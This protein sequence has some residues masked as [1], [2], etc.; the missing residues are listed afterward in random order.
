MAESVKL[1][2]LK[3]SESEFYQVLKERVNSYFET[4]K[5]SKHANGHMVFKTF[6][7]LSM[8]GLTYA[9]VL[10]NPFHPL[11]QLVIAMALGF[12]TAL[13]GLNI[14][15]DALH[16]AYSSNQKI[17]SWLGITFNLIGA[18]DYIW[19]IKH[20]IIHH[21]FTNIPDH[22]DDIN[23]AKIL[24]MEPTQK[25]KPIHRYQHFYIFL[26]YPLSSLSW[27]FVKDFEKFFKAKISS[28]VIKNHPK[29]ELYRLIFFKLVYYTIYIVIPFTVIDLPWYYILIGFIAMHLVEGATLSFIFQL[30]HVFEGNSYPQPDKEG[31]LSRPWADHQ[32]FTTANFGK[33]SPVLNFLFGGLNMQ[34]EHH[35]FPRICHV[36]YKNIS[37]IVQSTARE[38]NLP[39]LESKTFGGAIRSHMDMMKRL[40]RED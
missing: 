29:I 26:L 25:R 37:P 28:K 2:F 39:Y 10:I 30:A 38:F 23:Q 35:L 8:V 40:G 4:N 24:R 22:D 7:I 17:N 15:H 34:V 27:V 5:I 19:K 20:N 9:L 6:F 16:G 32:L 3:N 18:N 36:H 21:T 1:T 31:K 14:A 12:F 33:D 11:I 13:I